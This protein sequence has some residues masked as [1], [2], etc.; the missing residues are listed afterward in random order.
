MLRYAGA[1]QYNFSAAD[2]SA[3]PGISKMITEG[4]TAALVFGHRPLFKLAKGAFRLAGRG[5]VGLAKGLGRGALGGAKLVKRH[6]I[7]SAVIGTGI[8]GGMAVRELDKR[9]G[10][11]SPLQD[12]LVQAMHDSRGNYL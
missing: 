11:T 4:V 9:I 2:T 6:P 5:G 3:G 7:R 8:V 10:L 12:G 1:T